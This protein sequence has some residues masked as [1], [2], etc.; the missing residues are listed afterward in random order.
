MDA[1][2]HAAAYLP[3]SQL[4]PLDTRTGADPV[5]SHGPHVAAGAFR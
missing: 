3:G 5:P 2:R 1:P 4:W